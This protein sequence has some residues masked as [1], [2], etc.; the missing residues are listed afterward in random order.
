MK[1][2]LMRGLVLLMM[3]MLAAVADAAQE[4]E[5]GRIIGL[6][7]QAWVERGEARL[8]AEL[9]MPLFVTD[10]VLTDTTGRVQI[11]LGDDST[12]SAAP[13]TFLRLDEFVYDETGDA[14]FAMRMTG[15]VARVVTGAIVRKNPEGFRITTP[16]ATIGIRG[17]DCSIIVSGDTTTVVANRITTR[18]ILVINNATGER[19]SLAA[20]GMAVD[21]GPAGNVLRPATDDERVTATQAMRRNDDAISVTAAA[22]PGSYVGIPGSGALHLEQDDAPL[23]G[24]D[25]KGLMA[26]VSGDLPEDLPFVYTPADISGT[27]SGDFGT[28]EVNFFPLRTGSSP[29]NVEGSYSFSV[30]L[31]S[32]QVTGGKID[33]EQAG[34]TLLFSANGLGGMIGADMGFAASGNAFAGTSGAFDGVTLNPSLTGSF[35]SSTGAL[36]DID[37]DAGIKAYTWADLDGKSFTQASCK[38]TNF[39]MQLLGNAGTFSADSFS[40]SVNL[41]SGG[42]TNAEMQVTIDG[43]TYTPRNGT[44]NIDSSDRNL[45]FHIGNWNDLGGLSSAELTGKFDPYTGTP[46]NVVGKVGR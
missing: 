38:L 17:T 45:N 29:M 6:S 10:A 18:D 26:S 31:G 39:T 28:R 16:Q 42:I 40:F 12:I 14:S 2:R 30:N 5:A 24:V 19:T 25:L 4:N 46:E 33:I 3:G 11:L 44:G 32:G 20:S 15:G 1:M 7:P 35:D 22:L 36:S 27:F 8:P 37:W 34:G 41:A 43:T 21:V 13:D 23:P 9:R